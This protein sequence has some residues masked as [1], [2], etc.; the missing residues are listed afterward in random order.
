V[1]LGDFLISCK[2]KTEATISWSSAEDEY[3]ALAATACNLV[4]HE[5]TKYIEIDCHLIRDLV[6]S[7][8]IRVIEVQTTNQLADVM[9]KPLGASI[10]LS[11]V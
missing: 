5:R 6:I 8:S 9:R 10:F 4:A 2:S 11:L 1:Y 3:R 7:S